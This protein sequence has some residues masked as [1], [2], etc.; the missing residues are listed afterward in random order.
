MQGGSLTVQEGE[1]MLNGGDVDAQLQ[2][3]VG[4]QVSSEGR[5][6]RCGRCGNT[7]HNAR[8]CQSG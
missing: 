5:Q 6:R 4:A 8:T 3:E 1:D 2:A 7:G